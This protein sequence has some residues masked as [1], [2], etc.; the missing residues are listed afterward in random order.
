ME[1]KKLLA[2]GIIFLFIGVAVAPSINANIHDQSI[3]QSLPP[4]TTKTIEVIRYEYKSDG[5]IE[6]KILEMPQ[7]EFYKFQDEFRFTQTTEEKLDIYKKY[8]LIPQNVSMASLRKNFH[9]DVERVSQSSTSIINYAQNTFKKIHLKNF[10]P[11]GFM[12][13]TN[14]DVYGED[15]FTLR[16]SLGL[17]PFVGRFNFLLLL[18]SPGWEAQSRD[19]V[20]CRVSGYGDILTNGTLGEKFCAGQ[21]FFLSM[22]GFVGYILLCPFFLTFYEFFVGFAKVTVALAI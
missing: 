11:S 7:N 22:M 17:S 4:V 12:V 8:D 5:K 13:N 16:L 6:K 21:P 14:C 15:G 1:M 2:L 20:L 18:L 19:F 9:D 3:Q 10:S